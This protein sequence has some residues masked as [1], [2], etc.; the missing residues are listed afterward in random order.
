MT[1]SFLLVGT[2]IGLNILMSEL[3]Q[4]FKPIDH[5]LDGLPLLI[6]EN[7]KPLHHRMAKERVDVDDVLDAAREHQGLERLDQIRYAVL[8]RNGKISI[9]P[10]D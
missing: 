10:A 9:I 2:L 5:V 6:V 1:N 3:K 4:H 7:G 8:E